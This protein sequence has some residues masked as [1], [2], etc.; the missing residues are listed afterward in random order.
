[1]RLELRATAGRTCPGSALPLSR[2]IGARATHNAL[3]SRAHHNHGL[4]CTGPPTW[5]ACFIRR[6]ALAL[7]AFAELL[8]FELES[9]FLSVVEVAETDGDFVEFGGGLLATT[10]GALARHASAEHSAEKIA[11]IEGEWYRA[12]TSLLHLWIGIGARLVID[13][14][15][16]FI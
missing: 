13:G 9:D 14:S 7:A 4:P 15:A 10:A 1:L 16:L 6:G 8:A 12:S 5:R 3:H 2:T 11:H